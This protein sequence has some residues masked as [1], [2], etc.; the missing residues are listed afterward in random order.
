MGRCV[1]LISV[2]SVILD[3]H[4]KERDPETRIVNR[5]KRRDGRDCAVCGV[6]VEAHAFVGAPVE[7]EVLGREEG[8]ASGVDGFHV[9]DFNAIG[10]HMDLSAVD[11]AARIEVTVGCTDE[12]ANGLVCMILVLRIRIEVE[13]DAIRHAGG[14]LSGRHGVADKRGFDE[15]LKEADLKRLRSLGRGGHFKSKIAS[16]VA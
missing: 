12:V 7:V 1:G 15:A 3:H 2:F 9:D 8:F 14:A 10:D 11:S 16:D 13:D 4:A 6:R 5:R